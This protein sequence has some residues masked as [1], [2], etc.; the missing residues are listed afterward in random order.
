MTLVK[1]VMAFIITVES[2]TGNVRNFDSC[3]KT[4][5]FYS[6]TTLDQDNFDRP[7]IFVLRHEEVVLMGSILGNFHAD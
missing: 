4:T 6:T 7:V 2:M 1:G 3:A 5:V